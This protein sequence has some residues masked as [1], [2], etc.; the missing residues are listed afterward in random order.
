MP[1]KSQIARS[2][3]FRHPSSRLAL[4]QPGNS[5]GHGKSLSASHSCVES[6]QTV[7]ESA[8]NGPHDSAYDTPAGEY[9]SNANVVPV[10]QANAASH[11][12]KLSSARS[13]RRTSPELSESASLNTKLARTRPQFSTYQQHFTPKRVPKALTE[14]VKDPH[15][16]G[17]PSHSVS[18]ETSQ[19]QDELLQLSLIYT[20]AH[21]AK[22]EWEQNAKKQMQRQFKRIVRQSEEQAFTEQTQQTHHNLDTL[23]QWLNQGS[24]PPT[25]KL[26]VLSQY[27]RDIKNLMRSDGK[28]MYVIKTF[29]EW[30]SL[31]TSATDSKDDQEVTSIDPLGSLWKDQ[32]QAAIQALEHCQRQLQKLGP[33]DITG[34]IG[35]TLDYHAKIAT[36]TIA[37]LNLM[38]EV[39]GMTLEYVREY[40]TRAI[41]EILVLAESELLP[42]ET[43][44]KGIW[45]TI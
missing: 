5:R 22:R 27:I 28:A 19:L 4:T 15:L 34:A 12:R 10:R 45:N 24:H 6:L 14:D 30:L 8:K 31:V 40:T 42:S 32:A 17:D 1:Q 13:I 20:S 3:S 2:S 35:K 9:E 21:L 38:L 29:Q 11:Q 18:I 23:Q 37:E 39:E 7:A 41:T 25:E 33:T 44:R 26:E 36:Q 16:E 43:P